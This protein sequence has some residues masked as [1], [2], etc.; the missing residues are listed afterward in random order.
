MNI[1]QN[2]VLSNSIYGD[3][4]RSKCVHRAWGPL[5]KAGCGNRKARGLEELR[6]HRPNN[7]ADGVLNLGRG[8]YKRSTGYILL[9]I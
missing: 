6:A 8:D 9:A 4:V 7:L 5:C 1:A 2:S 3:D